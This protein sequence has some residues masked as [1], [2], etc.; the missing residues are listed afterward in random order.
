MPRPPVHL[1]GILSSLLGLGAVLLVVAYLQ[2]PPPQSAPEA[3]HLEI[4]VQAE[5][6]APAATA[7][8]PAAPRSQAGAGEAGTLSV[9][10]ALEAGA[11][12][13]EP[14]ELGKSITVEAD[15]DEAMHRLEH[16]FTQHPPGGDRFRLTF[17]P[18]GAW[19][20][21]RRALHEA[22]RDSE[23]RRRDTRVRVALPTGV[24]MD[25]KLELGKG[26]AHVDLSGLSLRRLQIV[27]AMG[28]ARIVF[29]APN[30]IAMESFELR[31][32]MGELRAT[33]LGY[34]R[35][36]ALD[37]S[38]RMGHFELDLDG[39]WE[40]DVDGSVRVSMGDAVVRVPHDLQLQM[41]NRGV[42]FGGLHTPRAARRRDAEAGAATLTLQTSVQFGNLDIR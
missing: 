13:I 4:P 11:F 12:E 25:L 1:P 33:G 26:N 5:Q 30:P 37:F 41:S 16:E 27:H 20:H 22:G 42:I 14:A 3:R 39:P 34:A 28:E 23:R 38:G 24:P 15:Y 2:G 10:I 6:E 8:E 40:T 17:A 35:A 32:K 29:D 31:G 21:L 36:R 18:R 9:E 7:G 19:R